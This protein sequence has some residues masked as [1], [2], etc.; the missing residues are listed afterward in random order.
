[1]PRVLRA[2]AMGLT[3]L[4]ASHESFHVP[5]FQRVYGWGEVEIKRLLGDLT[6]A[7]GAPDQRLFLG[8]VYLAT[9][10]GSVSAQVADGQQRLL[11]A[12]ILYAVARDLSPPQDSEPLQELVMSPVTDQPR[13][14][15]RDRDAAFLRRWVQEPGATLRPFAEPSAPG[16][17]AQHDDPEAELSESQRNV[18]ANRDMLVERLKALGAD[19]LRSL[20]A[21]L[22]ARTDLVVITAPSIEEARNAYASTQTRGLRQAETDKLKAELVGDCPAPLRARLAGQWEECEAMLGKEDLAELLQWMIVIA[23]E[24]KPQHAIEVDLFKTFDLPHAVERFVATELV[25]SAAAYKALCG[26][27]LGGSRSGRR[28][29]GHLVT[30]LRTTHDSWKAPALLALRRYENDPPMLEAALRDL[31]RLAASLMIRGVDP[32]LMIERYIAVIRALKTPGAGLGQLDLSSKEKAETRTALADNRFAIRDRFRMPLLLKINDLLTG[33][34]QDVDPK[35]VSCEHILPRNALS[36][37]PWR[38]VFGGGSGGRYQGGR[39]VHMLGNLTV[40]PHDENRRADTHPYAQKRQIFKRS[41]LAISKEAVT[42]KDWT[43]EVI[44]ARTQR[45]GKLL[46]DHWRLA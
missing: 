15:P 18:I 24:R 1:M 26:R 21:Y 13:F 23:G 16:D 14:M 41:A 2:S 42:W 37:S 17:A 5:E 34:V 10:E 30:L 12:S 45:L 44:Q 27:D 31:E 8:T 19:G 32:N 43:P 4:L 46:I 25:P 22:A 20:V 29:A 38:T 7:L 3:D 11:T 36:G 39:Y 40:L 33:S 35:T 9:P 28:I 6:T